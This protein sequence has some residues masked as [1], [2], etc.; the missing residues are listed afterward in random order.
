MDSA[1]LQFMEWLKKQPAWLQDATW[2][3]FNGKKID[4][5]Q[6]GKYA[7]MCIAQVKG[8]KVE[9]KSID[10]P[11]FSTSNVRPVVSIRSISEIVGVNAL[12]DEAGLDFAEKGVSVVYGLNG[13]GKSGYMR[14][15]KQVCMISYATILCV[16]K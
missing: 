14:I 9:P 10:E 4:S 6:I 2:R 12:S 5:A 1:Y 11:V 7:D 8:D 3:I 15:F 16:K 13:A